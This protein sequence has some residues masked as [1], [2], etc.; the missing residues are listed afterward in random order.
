MNILEHLKTAPSIQEIEDTQLIKSQYKYWRSRIFI[1]MF[2]GYI[3]YYFSRKGFTVVMPFLMSELGFTKPDLGKI[4]SILSI[5]YG[6]SKFMSG[7]ISDRSNPRYFMGIG[8]I[9]TGI[10]NFC[11]GLSSSLLFFSIFWGLNGW[12]QGCGW[13]P[14]ARLL[15]HWYSQSERGTWWGFWNTAHG[16]GG[17]VIPLLTAVCVQN[18]GWRYG[19][20]APGVVCILMG[21][22]VI[23]RLRDTPQSLGLPPVEKFKND[24]E[25]TKKT[26]DKELSTKQLLLEFVLKNKYLWLLSIAYFFIYAIREGFTSWSCLFLMEKKG[27]SLIAAGSC[28]CWFEIGGICGSLASGWLSDRIFGGR[29]NP[30]NILFGLA[31]IAAIVFFWS[32]TGGWIIVDSMILFAAGFFIFGPQMLIGIAAIEFS[33]KKVAGTASGFAGCVACIGAACAGYPLSLIAQTWG[34]YGFFLTLGVCGAISSLILLPLWKMRTH[35][36]YTEETILERTAA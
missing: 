14:C 32:Y 36:K 24:Y 1:G 10:F 30:I 8:L 18:W 11:F 7:I 20:Y 9:L 29:R 13:P 21:L 34:W 22:F 15:T 12:F 4:G 31:I 2:V 5:S 28:F 23:N 26:E 27:Y 19:L 6:V 3:F 16:I 35:P 25:E 33:H 17:G